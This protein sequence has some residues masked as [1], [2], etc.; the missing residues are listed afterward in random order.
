MAEKL[1]KLTDDEIALMP[2]VVD[3]WVKIGLATGRSDRKLVE[4]AV[5]EA[6]KV[7]DLPPPGKFMWFD[8]PF[9]AAAYIHKN[10]GGVFDNVIYGQHDIYFLSF[11]DFF[12]QIDSVDIPEIKKLHP[13]MTIAANAGWWWAYD[14]LTI[15][16][17]RP[18][19]LHRDAAGRL[20]AENGMAIKYFD[21]NGLYSWHGYTIPNE[22]TWIITDKDRLNPDVIE[23][24][25]N[26]ELRRIMLEIYGFDRYLSERNSK[27]IS[28]DV[29]GAGNPRRL[30]EMQVAGQP[31]RI[32][33]VNNSTLEPDG[34]RRK[35]HLGAM[36]GSTPHEVI[37]ASFGFNPEKF[38]EEV[39]S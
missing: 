31:V 5:N 15:I 17:E 39:C 10:I 37:A 7:A 3:K 26:A 6:Y 25:T 2:K 21:G 34:T 14:E 28:E 9:A 19:E 4:E 38:N 35:F 13:M 20:H 12:D 11:Y 36:P 18:E 16:T 22:N 23:K 27:V 32:I 24:E 1:T 30:I 33:E 29:D 8:S